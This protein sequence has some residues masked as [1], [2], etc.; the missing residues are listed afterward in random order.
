MTVGKGQDQFPEEYPFNFRKQKCG[1]STTTAHR[2]YSL[3][4]HNSKSNWRMFKDT[5]AFNG[6]FKMLRDS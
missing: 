5:Y 2:N 6:K 1:S 3:E 4:F